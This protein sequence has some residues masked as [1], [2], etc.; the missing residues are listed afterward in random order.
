M[1][2]T[3]ARTQKH[4]R[5]GTAPEPARDRDRKRK[6]NGRP[7]PAKRGAP[8]KN[9]KLSASTAD[10]YVL[11]QKSVQ[12]PAG[13]VEFVAST[14]TAMRRRNART[15]REDF[16]GTAL[17]CVA[18]VQVDP[19]TKT[20]TGVD[21]DPGVLDWAVA[22]NLAP[23]PDA[24]ASRITLLQQDVREPTSEKFDVVVAFNFS[25]WVFQTREELGR[26]FR[27]VYE[28]LAKD[29]LFFLD[30]YG[31]W[32]S[33]QPMTEERPVSGGFTYIWDQHEVDPITGHIVNHIHFEF[34]DG[35]RMDRAFTYEWRFWSLPELR[36]ILEA[37]G[38]SR[39]TI[40][41]DNAETEGE[42]DYRPT[43]CASNQPGWIAYIV[44]SK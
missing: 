32:E 33:H 25:Y 18:W 43:K 35:S 9:G 29:G 23:L 10:K 40:Y 15:L 6:S 26:Y 13:E 22:H 36:E 1:T 7:G 20:A 41:W 31:G 37:A 24:V 44:A 27:T 8:G 38:F 42:E 17:F 16:C 28:S 19:R 39:V 4:R 5:P 3:S 11:Y 21:L 30:A 14:Y 2:N 34:P 12:N